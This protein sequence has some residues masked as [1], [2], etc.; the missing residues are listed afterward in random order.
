[1]AVLLWILVIC[2]L[3]A[4]IIH[5]RRS[6]EKEKIDKGFSFSYWRLSYRRKFIRTLWFI[7]LAV[8]VI[9]LVHAAYR[10]YVITLVSGVFILAVILTQ[11]IYNYKKWK[12]ES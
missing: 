7:P 6:G 2:L 11:A 5:I 9:I 8:L 10:S 4:L 3:V 1:M 12:E